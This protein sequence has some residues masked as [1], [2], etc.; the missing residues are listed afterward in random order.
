MESQTSSQAELETETKDEDTRESLTP[1]QSEDQVSFSS[2]QFD[3]VANLDPS[4]LP[5]TEASAAGGETLTA[6]TAG[7][8]TSQDDQPSTSTEESNVASQGNNF[9]DKA[10]QL[11]T[12]RRR[13]RMEHNRVFATEGGT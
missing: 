1:Q 8:S 4:P 5:D 13:S 6:A 9:W 2:Q 11:A 3:H 12:Q 10:R 7:S